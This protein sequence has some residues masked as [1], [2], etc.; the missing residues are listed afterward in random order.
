MQHLGFLTKVLLEGDKCLRIQ[1][2]YPSQGKKQLA[3][4]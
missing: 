1:L 3:Y 4:S 2:G